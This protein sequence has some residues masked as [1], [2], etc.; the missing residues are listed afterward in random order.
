MAKEAT[1]GIVGGGI[2]G[3]SVLFKLNRLG[4]SCI[5]LEKNADLMSEASGGNR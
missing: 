4:Y 1:I 3:C 5:L 2:I